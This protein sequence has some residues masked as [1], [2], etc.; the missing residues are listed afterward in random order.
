MIVIASLRFISQCMP[1]RLQ[2]MSKLTQH[3][4]KRLEDGNKPAYLMIADLIAEDVRSGRLSVRDRLPPLRDLAEALQLNYT[5][6][7]RGYAEARKR[8]LIDS[9]AGMGTFIRGSNPALPLRGGSSAEMTM[10]MPPEIQ[11]PLLLQRLR[12]R[13]AAALG[14]VDMHDLLR[15]QDFGGSQQ[16]REAGAQWMS[17]LLP[18]LPTDRVLVCP[19]IQATLTTLLSLLARP[20]ESI[21]V[22][23]LTY[24]GIK[25]I[26]TQLGVRLHALPLDDEGPSAAAFEEACKTLQPKALYCNPTLLNPT[27]L[28]L[29]PKRREALADVA[30]R[31]N[32]PIIEDD[33][34]ALLPR[35]SPTPLALLAPELTY[36]LTGFSKVL[37]AGLRTAY[38]VAPS[39][40]QAQRLAGALRTTTVMTSPITSVLATQWIHD[41]IATTMLQAIRKESMARQELAA[42][43]LA[44]HPYQA[45][46][47]GFHLWLP[48]PSS[49]GAEIAAY[50]RSQG[51]GAVASAAF[52]TDG[53]PP[54][55]LRICLGGPLSREQ[56]DDALQRIADTLDHPTDL[57]AQVM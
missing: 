54:D 3:W 8:G 50:L 35:Q 40:R 18:S 24:S 42:K 9:R 46:A 1:P 17:P 31:F 7:A 43:R 56:C 53:H 45:Q 44:R 33:A 16:D 23:S 15:Y 4:P 27:T 47:E 5:T 29:S 2:T 26:A 41:G 12:E 28:T 22:E 14:A 34:Y 55:A 20:G 11:D 52:A 37:G 19:G 30:L 13:G 10:N 32:V 38:A 21:C 51:V 49:N 39:A 36:Y 6:V 25:A 48:L 57:H